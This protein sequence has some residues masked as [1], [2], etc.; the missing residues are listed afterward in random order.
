M[1][2]LRDEM[3]PGEMANWRYGFNSE[4]DY[5]WWWCNLGHSAVEVSVLLFGA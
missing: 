4:D 2:F 1:M 3:V 5:Q